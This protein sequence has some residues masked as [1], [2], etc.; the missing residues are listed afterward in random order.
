GEVTPV[1]IPNT[2]VKLSSADGT[3]TA[4]SWES[5]SSPG[6]CSSIAQSVEHAAVN[7]R[8]VGSSPT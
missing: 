8:V 1:P 3:W 4:G 5:K 7:R 6:N 2:E